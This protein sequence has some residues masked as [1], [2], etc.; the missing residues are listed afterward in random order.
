MTDRDDLGE[1]TVES[2]AAGG[3]AIARAPDGR[4]VF[5]ARAAPGDRV[6]VRVLETKKS[7]YRAEVAEVIAPGP[8]RVEPRCPLFIAGTCGGCQWQH[9]SAAAQAAA[10]DQLVRAALRHLVD[11]GLEV[12]PLA[13][14]L[15]GYEWRRRTRLHWVRPRNAERALVGFT[16]P[17]SQRL[18]DVEACVQL[19]PALGRALEAVRATLAPQLTGRGDLELIAGHRGEVHLAVRGPCAPR[20]AAAM[21]GQGG[22]VG[23]V[24]GRQ[25]FGAGDLELEPGLRGRADW[26]AQASRAGNQLLAQVVDLA[27]R[28][29]DDQRILELYAGSG[30]LTRV[31]AR[32][33]AEVVAVDRAVPAPAAELPDHVQHR[34]GAVEE[35]AAVCA[36]RHERFDLVVLDPPR[37]GAAAVL[38]AVIELGAARVVYV[39]CD[40]ATL[41]RDAE[42]L[43]A[44][45]YRPVRATPLDLMP[46]TSHVETVLSL[47]RSTAGTS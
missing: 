14:P 13:R 29:R 18:V 34:Q 47:E 27:T 33:A 1:L 37:T 45:G 17:R 5:V 11:G 8:D 40:L 23:V 2:L 4:V 43:I 19:E 22:I 38:P 32:G 28:P 6:R 20:A 42:A 7:F 39:S 24:L 16:A 31:L 15:P 36:R 41:A 25:V 35:V 12:A 10:K 9:V 46:Q 26:F 3:D 30:N 44:A 21:V